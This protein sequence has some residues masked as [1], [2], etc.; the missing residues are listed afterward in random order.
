MAQS[1]HARRSRVSAVFR[2]RHALPRTVCRCGAT[3]SQLTAA[4]RLA[5]CRRTDECSASRRVSLRSKTDGCA[6]CVGTFALG[7]LQC[8]IVVACCSTA[9]SQQESTAD[10]LQRLRSKNGCFVRKLGSVVSSVGRLADRVEFRGAHARPHVLESRTAA[11]KHHARR[12]A[13][14]QGMVTRSGHE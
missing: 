3:D 8:T 12:A 10:P 6:V 11:S 7:W 14:I 2:H 9:L 1:R 5:V 4:A 13:P